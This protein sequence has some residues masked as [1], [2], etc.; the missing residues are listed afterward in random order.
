MWTLFQTILFATSKTLVQKHNVPLRK[1]FFILV[2]T[3]RRFFCFD[4]PCLW[5]NRWWKYKI[6]TKRSDWLLITK[7]KNDIHEWKV[8][9]PQP[10]FKNWSISFRYHWMLINWVW[11]ANEP[12]FE[13]FG[14]LL[15]HGC[16][17]MDSFTLLGWFVNATPHLDVVA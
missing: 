1:L 12:S 16:L 8:K 15:T 17:M 2:L 3:F 14:C 13:L 5:P 7:H 11:F 9:K 10:S 4:K 6:L